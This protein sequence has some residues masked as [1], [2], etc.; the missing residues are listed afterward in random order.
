MLTSF[1]QL[2]SFSLVQRR[3]FGQYL[4]PVSLLNRFR[5]KLNIGTL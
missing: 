4:D 5:V 3:D 1:H 2:S